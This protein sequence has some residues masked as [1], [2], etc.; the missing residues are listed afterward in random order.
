MTQ[1]RSTTADTGA[2]Y[3]P[4]APSRHVVGHGIDVVD[5]ARFMP[6]VAR[7]QE[8]FLTRCFSARELSIVGN[9][10][11]RVSRLAARFAAKEAVIKALG[12][13]RDGMTLPQIEVRS[14]ASGAPSV[15]LH[16]TTAAIA[17]ELGI[18]EWKLTV[19]HTAS[20][21]MASVIALGA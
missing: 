20:F 17:A 18:T 3:S 5:V 2:T 11:Q 8:L 9:G 6:T 15:E 14:T 10:A 19:S 1:P 4:P 12:G 7:E 21:A 16:G 13:W